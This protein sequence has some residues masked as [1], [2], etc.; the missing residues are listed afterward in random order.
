[1]ARSAKAAD[2]TAKAADDTAK[3]TEAGNR[4]RAFK[5]GVE[6]LGNDKSSVRQGGA[7]ALFH[8]ALEG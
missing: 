5:D 3:A 8:L 2:N 7:H 6:H 1:M 4:Q